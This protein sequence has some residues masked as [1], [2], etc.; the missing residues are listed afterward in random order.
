MYL[1]E[2]IHVCTL[3]I[4]ELMMIHWGDIC[5]HWHFC[6]QSECGITARKSCCEWIM[7]TIDTSR[8]KH[9]SWRS[10]CLWWTKFLNCVF[11]FGVVRKGWQIVCFWRCVN[12]GG[13]V[14]RLIWVKGSQ[15]NEEKGRAAF[16]E[17]SLSSWD[18]L[19]CQS[20]KQSEQ[21]CGCITCMCV[22]SSVCAPIL[23]QKLRCVA[24]HFLPSAPS[25]L[26]SLWNFI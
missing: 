8:E 26:C 15:Q 20:E 18:I 9:F 19:V 16:W 4:P 14:K 22:M 13:K 25:L 24:F 17:S 7:I 21:K 10:C 5:I 1:N 12:V 23:R 6:F 3:S 11:S 2:L